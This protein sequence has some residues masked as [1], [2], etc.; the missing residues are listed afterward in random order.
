[1]NEE[2]ENTG[3]FYFSIKANEINENIFAF[4]GIYYITSSFY[5]QE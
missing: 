5:D 2:K 3:I 4:K 1:M